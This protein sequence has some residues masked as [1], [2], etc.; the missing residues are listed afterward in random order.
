M[1]ELKSFDV[2][3]LHRL[4]NQNDEELVRIISENRIPIEV[5]RKSSIPG[6]FEMITANNYQHPEETIYKS[7]RD[8]LT[9]ISNGESNLDEINQVF[10]K[11]LNPRGI[12]QLNVYLLRNGGVSEDNIDKLTEEFSKTIQ[13]K[14]ALL[15]GQPAYRIKVVELDGDNVSNSE[16]Y[17]SI[18]L[19]PRSGGQEILV[20]MPKVAKAVY[21]WFLLNPR[22]EIEAKKTP[23]AFGREVVSLY[24]DLFET[25]DAQYRNLVK[26]M[27]NDSGVASIMQKQS[28]AAND[29]I[30]QALNGSDIPD[31]YVIRKERGVYS[32]GIDEDLI[33]VSPTL[34]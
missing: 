17:W 4:V 25:L 29:A 3:L 21:I 30:K 12:D 5:R 2:D 28:G 34:Y 10:K 14:E 27:S 16:G 19:V 9:E 13:D 24:G 32:I 7:V 20:Q 18:Y 26:N 6:V 15:V 11:Y 23:S 8:I 31:W 1:N 22:I 33:D